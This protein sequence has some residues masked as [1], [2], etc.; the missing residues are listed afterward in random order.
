MYKETK[1]KFF[2]R[3]NKSVLSQITLYLEEDDHKPSD[4]DGEMISFTCQLFK[5]Q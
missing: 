2:K 3:I 1:K 5:V 4:L